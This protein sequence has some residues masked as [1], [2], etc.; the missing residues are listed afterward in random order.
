[1]LSL[2]AC[3]LVYV[4]FEVACCNTVM[5][6][7]LLWCI[8]IAFPISEWS[9]QK[10]LMHAF[11]Q[12]HN[13]VRRSDLIKAW[14]PSLSNERNLSINVSCFLLVGLFICWFVGYFLR[15]AANGTAFFY[16]SVKDRIA[17]HLMCRFSCD[18]CLQMKAMCVLLRSLS[19]V[20]PSDFLHCRL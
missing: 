14:G 16:T 13:C 6:A 20:F 19:K 7:P 17:K 2:N 10:W 8:E 4:G 5:K 3:F 15:F 12:G 18:S 9:V 1:M 11:S